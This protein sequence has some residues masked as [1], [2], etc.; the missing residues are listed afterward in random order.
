MKR[1][2]CWRMPWTVCR[3][4]IARLSCCGHLEGLSF[5]EVANR[6][7]R[8]VDSVEKLWVRAAGNCGRRWP[9]TMPAES[10]ESP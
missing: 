9:N 7:G 2:S 3:P 6:M 8:S 1:P 4:I 10:G 5:A